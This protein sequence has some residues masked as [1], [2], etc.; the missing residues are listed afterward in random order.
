MPDGTS[1]HGPLLEVKANSNRTLKGLARLESGLHGAGREAGKAGE[2]TGSL[3]RPRAGMA[4]GFRAG[5][6]RLHG[7]REAR[8]P[9]CLPSRS[10]A[11]PAP[12]A[13]GDGAAKQAAE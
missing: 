6:F 8:V 9:A 7:L 12:G 10:A 1:T 13:S 3:A 11:K 4:P 5:E 2:N